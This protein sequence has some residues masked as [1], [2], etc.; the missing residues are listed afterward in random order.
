[1][2]RGLNCKSTIKLKLIEVLRHMKYDIEMVKE[3]KEILNFALDHFPS[4]SIVIVSLHTLSVITQDSLFD[5]PQHIRLLFRYLKEDDRLKVKLRALR[6]IKM[7]IH[8]AVFHFP[9]ELISLDVFESFLTNQT[10][11]PLRKQSLLFYLTLSKFFL[12]PHLN[13][14]TAN[15]NNFINDDKIKIK[16]E[17]KINNNNDINN[18]NN[19]HYNINENEEKREEIIKRIT[20]E[21][22]IYLFDENI[23]ISQLCATILSYFNLSSQSIILSLCT[24]LSSE[25]LSPS[26]P[27]SSLPSSSPSH[28]LVILL[29]SF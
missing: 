20:K 18:I 29:F 13:K 26:S 8:N 5:I 21:C 19:I 27:S 11:F 1:M 9:F 14:N 25:L 22:Q 15:N 10:P 3:A 6:D 24:I 12:S 16:E 7:I 17:N 23:L 2:I 28:L 4:Q